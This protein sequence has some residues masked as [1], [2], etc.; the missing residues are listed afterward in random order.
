MFKKN[1]LDGVLQMQ[2]LHRSQHRYLADLTGQLKFET[3]YFSYLKHY[4]AIK[5]KRKLVKN[6]YCVYQMGYHLQQMVENHLCA[7]ACSLLCPVCVYSDFPC[8]R[9]VGHP[10]HETDSCYEYKHLILK[11][12]SSK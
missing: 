12:L 6:S 7:P 10:M 11:L 4:Y 5:K 8:V 3:K 2:Q 1:L 9:R